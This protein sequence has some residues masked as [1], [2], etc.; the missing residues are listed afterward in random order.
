MRYSKQVPVCITVLGLIVTT[1]FAPAYRGSSRGDVNSDHKINILDIQTVMFQV[2]HG[3]RPE[4]EADV[5]GDGKTDIRDFQFVLFQA[6]QPRS[7]E[8]TS[9]T[10]TSRNKAVPGKQ[11]RLI[12]QAQCRNPAVVDTDRDEARPA[13]HFLSQFPVVRISTRTERYLFTLT[14]HA[15]PVSV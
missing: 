12:A 4:A 14:P 13:F 11:L 6:N 2:I 7:E 8:E 9:P 10:E 1:A 3:S 15:P 5:N